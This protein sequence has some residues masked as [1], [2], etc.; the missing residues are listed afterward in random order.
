VTP[1]RRSSPRAG[2]SERKQQGVPDAHHHLVRHSADEG[3][4][5]GERHRRN[6]MQVDCRELLQSNLWTYDD[7]LATPRIDEVSGATLTVCRRPII[8]WRVR[9]STGP[10]RSGALNAN[11]QISPRPTLATAG[12]RARGRTRQLA[13]A[14]VRMPPVHGGWPRRVG[15]ARSR[16]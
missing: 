1:A 12:L 10:R 2:E 16:A 13:R 3:A 5:A 6:V 9:T 14:S 7:S 4:K 15:G 8:S 11:C